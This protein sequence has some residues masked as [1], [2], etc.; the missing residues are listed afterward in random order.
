MPVKG[1]DCFLKANHFISGVTHN[2]NGELGEQ[3]WVPQF[4]TRVSHHLAKPISLCLLVAE[5]FE[6]AKRQSPA[7]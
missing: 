3:S 4:E 5:D 2:P 6:W 1:S 7:Q